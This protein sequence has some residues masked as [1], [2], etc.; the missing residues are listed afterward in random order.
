[1]KSGI[2]NKEVFPNLYINLHNQLKNCLSRKT[3][4]NYCSV[5]LCILKKEGG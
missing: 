2:Y 4:K 3:W 1:M 5:Y